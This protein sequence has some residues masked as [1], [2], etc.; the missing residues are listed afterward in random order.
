MLEMFAKLLKALN[1]ES[2]PGQVSAAFILGMII[3]FTPLFSLH[4]VFILLLAFVLRINLSG[5][6]LAWSFFSAMAFLFDPLF[7]LLGESLL[8]SSSLTPYWTILYNNPFWRLSH[9]NN[10]LVLGSLSLSLGL[11][12]PLFF[13][14]QYLI[15]RYRQHL[16]KWI[17]KSKVGQFI[18][19]SKFF[20][21]YQSVND[22]RDPI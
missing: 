19:A 1:S 4:N 3:G 21:L 10:T 22:S 9:F 2:D 15:I 16:L 18:K 11:T 5:F 17:E 12:I 6:F 13:L 8:T 14:Y 20:R 7:N